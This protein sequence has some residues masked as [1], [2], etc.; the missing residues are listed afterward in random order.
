[1]FLFFV[2]IF[3]VVAYR[4]TRTYSILLHLS[5]D[6][7]TTKKSLDTILSERLTLAKEISILVEPYLPDEETDALKQFSAVIVRADLPANPPERILREQAVTRSLKTLLSKISPET[8]PDNNTFFEVTEKLFIAE[9]RLRK[10]AEL[11]QVLCVEYTQATSLFLGSIVA[12]LFGFNAPSP[13]PL[14]KMGTSG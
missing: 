13:F 6:A 11:Y 10:N 4:F 9:D 2:F 8:V 1:M 14:F 3:V 12:R 5:E 7:H